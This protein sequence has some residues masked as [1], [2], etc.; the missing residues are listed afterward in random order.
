MGVE[1]LKIT[2]GGSKN[3]DVLESVEK[4]ENVFSFILELR[5][6]RSFCS[7]KYASSRQVLCI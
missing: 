2:A 4:F 1:K 3:K 7:A 5:L 6:R